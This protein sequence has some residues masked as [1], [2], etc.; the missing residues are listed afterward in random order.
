MGISTI[1][2][3]NHNMRSAI[4]AMQDT[5]KVCTSQTSSFSLPLSL[6][7]PLLLSALNSLFLA[8]VSS[9]QKI[10]EAQSLMPVEKKIVS[11]KEV[12]RLQ[13]EDELKAAEAKYLPKKE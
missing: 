6:P 13:G 2:W 10:F 4:T 1:I 11:V 12:F 9:F 7:L 5:S 3:A 8:L